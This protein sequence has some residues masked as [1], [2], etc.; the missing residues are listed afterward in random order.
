VLNPPT[1]PEAWNVI[2][3]ASANVERL[4]QEKR[5][6]EVITQIPLCS[7]ALRT[8]AKDEKTPER[9]LRLKKCLQKGLALIDGVAAASVANDLAAATKTFGEWRDFLRELKKEFDPKIVNADISFCPMH[10]DFVS[11]DAATPCGKML[12]ETAATAYSIQ[13]HLRA[14]RRAIDAPD[15]QLRMSRLTAGRKTEVKVQL[16]RR[17]GAPV[18]L[19]DLMVHA[20]AADSPAHCGSIAR[21]LSSRTSDAHADGG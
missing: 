13:L 7:P 2:R 18:L 14:A 17:D 11:T 4:L 8:L 5:L 15:R 9:G 19:D 1:A 6:A 21:G 16:K 3:L 20:H 10:P 12:D